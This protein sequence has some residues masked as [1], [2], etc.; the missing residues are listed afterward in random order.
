MG[1]ITGTSQP[2]TISSGTIF[3]TTDT[4]YVKPRYD[5]TRCIIFYADTA[6]SGGWVDSA[7]VNNKLVEVGRYEGRC[8]Y[9]VFWQFGY[10]VHE[11][12]NYIGSDKWY[13]LTSDKSPMK[14]SIIVFQSK[15]L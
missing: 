11:R 1:H 13:Y 3:W 10:L 9:S 8:D 5:T 4:G 2:L 7:I 6:K 14:K 15:P 12:S